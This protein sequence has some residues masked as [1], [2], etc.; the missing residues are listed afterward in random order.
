M[1]DDEPDF[2]GDGDELENIKDTKVEATVEKSPPT[3][4]DNTS[5]QPLRRSSSEHKQMKDEPG[6]R[7]KKWQPRDSW[8]DYDYDSWDEWKRDDDASWEWWGNKKWS[9]SKGD[10][11]KP[12]HG[13]HSWGGDR[14]SNTK[15]E[16]PLVVP[17]KKGEGCS[18]WM[19]S[20]LMLMKTPKG[21][22]PWEVPGSEDWKGGW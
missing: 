12:A 17:Q 6:E 5:Q 16:A 18:S 10:N 8:E 19:N 15:V 22:Q 7:G 9:N 4:G 21:W 1:D 14:H 20:T 11:W 3:S 13:W 2:G